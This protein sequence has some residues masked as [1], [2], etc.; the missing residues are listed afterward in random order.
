MRGIDA[1]HPKAKETDMT[2]TAIYAALLGLLLLILP[3]NVIRICRSDRVSLGAGDRPLLERR[4]RAQGNFTE[5]VPIALILIAFVESAGG[6]P[7]LVHGL[8]LALVVGRLAHAIAL[9]KLTPRPAFRSVGIVLT[10]AVVV[11][12]SVR[13]LVGALA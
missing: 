5:Y 9:T 12:A 1:R 3:I 10:F 8:G 13:I 4:I 2:I 7:N 11:A 6:A